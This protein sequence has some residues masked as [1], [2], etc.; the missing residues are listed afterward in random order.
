ML[1]ALEPDVLAGFPG[2]RAALVVAHPGHELRVHGWL[3]RV[4]PRVFVLTDGGGA[5]GISRVHA[6]ARVLADAGADAGGVFGRLSDRAVYTAMLDGDLGLFCGLAD[7]LAVA[8]ADV[9]YVVGD[10]AEG[11]NP[12]HDVCRLLIDAAVARAGRVS[13]HA[14][15][16]FAFP[17][18]G[19]PREGMA[20]GRGGVELWL[21]DDALGRKLAAARG[22]RDL[23]GEL[24]G[25][26]DAVGEEAFRLEAFAPAG[27]PPLAGAETPYYE[28]HG[29]RRVAEGVYARVLRLREHVL[30]IAKALAR[31]GAR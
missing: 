29:A 26:L 17:L 2:R 3:E 7:E 6:T 15:G 23:A 4:R 21:D 27:A 14:P 18:T 20:P 9:D 25:T 1:S 16:N 28:R 30:P 13:G 31:G 24:R 19:G 10:A 8:L 22:Y 12:A 5:G 11:Y